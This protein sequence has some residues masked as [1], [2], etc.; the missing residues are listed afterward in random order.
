MA[1][2]VQWFFSLS[3]L[4]LCIQLKFPRSL[5]G[6]PCRHVAAEPTASQ[7]HMA[8]RPIE[9]SCAPLFADMEVPPTIES[10]SQPEVLLIDPGLEGFGGCH[11]DRKA[12]KMNFAV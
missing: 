7:R 3:G 11:F 10:M 12:L 1:F 6:D 4:C 5:S 2:A 9:K 8:A